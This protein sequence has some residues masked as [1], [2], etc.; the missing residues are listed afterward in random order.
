LK[1]CRK[2]MVGRRR[3]AFL[4][5]ADEDAH[6][7]AVWGFYWYGVFLVWGISLGAA[8]LAYKRVSRPIRNR[9]VRARSR[10]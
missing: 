10:E 6:P 5:R 9:E 2:S 3:G 1:D 4:L 7:A 8:A